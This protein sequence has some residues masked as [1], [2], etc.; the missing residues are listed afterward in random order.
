[1]RDRPWVDRVRRTSSMVHGKRRAAIRARRQIQSSVLGS[2]FG[3]SLSRSVV[4]FF[5]DFFSI[6]VLSRGRGR[7]A[8]FGPFPRIL[9]NVGLGLVDAQAVHEAID[10]GL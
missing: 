2:G 9:R 1:M 10:Y 4:A 3:A 8:F 6:V 7:P 5:R